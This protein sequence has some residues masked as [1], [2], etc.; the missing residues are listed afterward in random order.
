MSTLLPIAKLHT[1]FFV[2][3]ELNQDYVLQLGELLEAGVVLP[4]CLAS[5]DG[6]GYDLVD[7]R[8]RVAAYDLLGKTEVPCDVKNFANET[9]KIA[10]AFAANLGGP[11][12]PTRADMDYTIGLLIKNGLREKQ[13]VKLLPQ[14]P[15]SLVRRYVYNVQS[16]DAKRRMTEAVQAV[17]N[18]ETNAKDA[19]ERFDVDYESL[20]AKLSGARK[21]AKMEM[22]EIK[23]TMTSRHKSVSLKNANELKRLLAAYEDGEVLSKQVEDVFGHIRHLLRHMGKTTDDW[24][25]RWQAQA[26]TVEES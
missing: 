11:L 7:G 14:L 15:P 12:P 22:S 17:A 21:R 8:H 23:G 1:S 4:P 20:R 9:D 2:R 19:A 6:D 25:A 24:Y 10:A 18:G 16:K 5:P 3:T 26:N 13:I